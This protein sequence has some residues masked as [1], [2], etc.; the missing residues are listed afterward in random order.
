MITVGLMEG[1]GSLFLFVPKLRKY[2]AYL[3]VVVMIGASATRIIPLEELGWPVF[4]IGLIFALVAI[5]FLRKK[6][7]VLNVQ[8]E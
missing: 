8:V 3:L 2:G 4:P 7:T 6:L 1:L 5:L